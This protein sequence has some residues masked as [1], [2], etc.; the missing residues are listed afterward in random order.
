MERDIYPSKKVEKNKY[1]KNIKTTNFQK[2][3]WTEIKKIAK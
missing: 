3:V 2:L 1:M